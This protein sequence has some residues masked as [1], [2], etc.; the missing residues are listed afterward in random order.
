MAMPNLLAETIFSA[1]YCQ[2]Y[3]LSPENLC[4]SI[5]S[6]LYHVYPAVTSYID[7]NIMLELTNVS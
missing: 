4:I 1:R 7:R 2:G 5:L 6:V 3:T